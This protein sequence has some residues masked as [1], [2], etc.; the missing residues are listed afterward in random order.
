M[1]NYASSNSSMVI[2]DGGSFISIP[3]MDSTHHH[4]QCTLSSFSEKHE[5]AS[6]N[7]TLVITEETHQ[8]Y[9]TAS[10]SSN[11]PV[12]LMSPLIGSLPLIGR[13]PLIGSSS[14]G[15]SLG[16]SQSFLADPLSAT[17]GFPAGFHDGFSGVGL[18]ETRGI[19]L[20]ETSPLLSQY[21]PISVLD[22]PSDLN[23]YLRVLDDEPSH[24]FSP[25]VLESP[26]DLESF[27]S[28]FD[29]HPPTLGCDYVEEVQPHDN[30]V[31]ESHFSNQNLEQAHQ[32]STIEDLLVMC[33]RNLVLPN[34][35]SLDQLMD[36]DEQEDGNNMVSAS[37]A[38]LKSEV[39]IS[40]HPSRAQQGPF[41]PCLA[42]ATPLSPATD[43]VRPSTF[44]PSIQV[45]SP[46]P[47][48]LTRTPA[49]SDLRSRKGPFE[50]ERNEE[51]N[52]CIIRIRN[53]IPDNVKKVAFNMN[54]Y[55]SDLCLK[56][57]DCMRKSC[58]RAEMCQCNFD[59]T[60]GRFTLSIPNDC[61]LN[62][63]D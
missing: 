19:I 37:T 54:W 55:S 40:S 4:R 52:E 34:N 58:V 16:C 61:K 35:H 48:P 17:S 20:D 59:R 39:V 63:W 13:S 8:A 49:T 41:L 6:S 9:C 30:K 22:D 27:M 33:T 15:S 26:P 53:D 51:G 21:G 10:D 46:T 32:N 62:V 25:S 50:I 43:E 5:R 28:N 44:M 24:L 47:S 3:G 7:S 57:K 56:F 36:T 45:S 14:I 12:S 60:T 18:G 11:A 29:G 2:D 38:M 23:A 42:L 31:S 1:K